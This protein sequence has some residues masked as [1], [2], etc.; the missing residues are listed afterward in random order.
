MNENL[1]E[2]IIQIRAKMDQLDSDLKKVTGKTK[3]ASD[4]ISNQFKAIGN[5]LRN[6]FSVYLVKEAVQMFLGLARSIDEISD[7]AQRMGMSIKAFQ[8][9]SFAAKLSGAD[10]G[11]LQMG[12][13]QFTQKLNEVAEGSK[14][15]TASLLQLA[16]ASG[17]TINLEDRAQGFQDVINALASIS[18]ETDRAALAMEIFGARSA[19]SLLPMIASIA[20]LDTTQK[21][22]N[23]TIQDE[24]VKA[25][26]DLNDSVDTAKQ[27]LFVLMAEVL[28][29]F[30]PLAKLVAESVSAISSAFS[31]AA[32][33][34]NNW[35][36]A[37]NKAFAK[38]TPWVKE[39]TA[40]S[41]KAKEL[42]KHDGKTITME[43]D[44]K[45]KGQSSSRTSTGKDAALA[46]QKNIAELQAKE[47]KKKAIQDQMELA[48][49]FRVDVR[50]SFAGGITDAVRSGD[51]KS[52]ITSFFDGVFTA[53]TN[54][55][56]NQIADA[57]FG[58]TSTTGGSEGY[59][60]TI[61][62]GL[63]GVAGA[64]A[65][66]APSSAP[67]TAQAGSIAGVA[68]TG[69]TINGGRSY[70]VGERGPEIFTPNS[71]GYVTPNNGVGGGSVT[72]VQHNNFA[73]VDSVNR[74]TLNQALARNKSDTISAI[75]SGARNGGSF[76]KNLR[77]R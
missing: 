4:D 42:E 69:G 71:S 77:G 28:K 39:M 56:A 34:V 60:G 58:S 62:S 49:S 22:F 55:F 54:K 26:A 18:N 5:T 17:R 20:E 52:G 35:L 73:G 27:T 68:A 33:S 43:V 63:F 72:I 37:Q 11:N 21:R 6:V 19:Q 74:Q 50:N 32:A 66:Q 57:M 61:V 53:I 31:S 23:V 9:L 51:L 14:Q 30:V 15:A 13:A 47:A 38:D 1:G 10:V 59:I 25:Y 7:S 64:G 36:S 65:G 75:Q 48:Q 29:P 16:E 46:M 76:A 24:T 3:Q 40:A 12:M 67:T 8:Q 41:D 70:L 44:V 2:A 45:E